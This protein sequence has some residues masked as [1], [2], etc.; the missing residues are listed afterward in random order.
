[1]TV[2]EWH[3]LDDV[4]KLPRLD[5]L[6]PFAAL[7]AAADIASGEATQHRFMNVVQPTIRTK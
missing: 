5:S 4:P 7:H 3:R 6:I 2:M 1:M